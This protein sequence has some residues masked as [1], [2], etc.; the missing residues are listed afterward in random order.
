MT[1]NLKA[2]FFDMGSTL[3]HQTPIREQLLTDFLSQRGYQ[4]STR[5]VSRAIL[6]ADTWW[7]KWGEQTPM[8]QRSDEVRRAMRQQYG[9]L[10]LQSL[11]L[12]STDGLRDEV[13]DIF[14]S[15]IT[16]RH[17]AIYPDV[18]PT[19]QALKQRGLRLAIVSNWDDS[20]MSHTDALGLTPIFDTIVGSQAVGYEK[21]AAWQRGY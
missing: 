6:S 2:V 13:N 12:E 15:S 16:R 20:L 10:F 7:H 17:D 11:G 3:S 4:R 9:S 18:M 8:A 5:E 21:H 14:R 1:T 19:L